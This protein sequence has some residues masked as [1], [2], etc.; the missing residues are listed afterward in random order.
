MAD[1]ART[2]AALK[3]FFETGDFPTQQQFADFIT[4]YANLVDNNQFDGFELDIVPVAPSDQSTAT[5]ITKRVTRCETWATPSGAIKLPIAVFNR[6]LLFV[7][8]T[9]QAIDVYPQSG[10][11]IANL[12]PNDFIT[13]QPFTNISFFCPLDGFWSTQ[14]LPTY[15]DNSSVIGFGGS[16][17]NVT[18]SSQ[19]TAFQLVG[20]ANTL[21]TTAGVLGGVK[22]PVAYFGMFV[23]V[24]NNGSNPSDIYPTSG[25]KILPSA[26]NAP[27]L[28][29]VGQSVLFYCVADNEWIA[30]ANGTI[31]SISRVYR[32]KLTQTGT[33]VPVATVLENTLGFVPTWYYNTVGGYSVIDTGKYPTGKTFVNGQAMIQ[34]IY[35]VTYSNPDNDTVSV[36]SFGD[37]VGTQA[38]DILFSTCVEIIIA[39]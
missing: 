23:S 14:S 21:T 8:D 15:G 34:G 30:L 5:V 39:P 13:I 2:A 3:L 12:A 35:P 32:A 7:N 31:S 6:T 36:A 24:E 27:Y 9:G 4:S 29:G 25:G 16:I 1:T 38:N 26:V 18:P 11:E 20:K 22:L 28:L 19:S 17:S 37:L 10:E 33:G